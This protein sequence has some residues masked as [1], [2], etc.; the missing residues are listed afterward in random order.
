MDPYGSV[1]SLLGHWGGDEG[2]PLVTTWAELFPQTPG[3]WLRQVRAREGPG[4]FHHGFSMWW[5]LSSI[6]MG[7]YIVAYSMRKNNDVYCIYIYRWCNGG[8]NHF[9]CSPQSLGKWSTLTN[10]FFRWVGSTTNEFFFFEVSGSSIMAWT[11]VEDPTCS[12]RHAGQQY[13]FVFHVFFWGGDCIRTVSNFW[14]PKI[15]QTDKTNAHFFCFPLWA[16][17]RETDGGNTIVVDFPSNSGNQ[18]Q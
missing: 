17:N 15:A 4:R 18:I 14:P 12:W 9:L 1:W 7:E 8:F 10:L 16:K 13:L 6:H 5:I 2:I 3:P 11:I